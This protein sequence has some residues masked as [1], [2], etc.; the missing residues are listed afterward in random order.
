MCCDQEQ[1]LLPPNRERL[2]KSNEDPAQSKI[3]KETVLKKKTDKEPWSTE[4]PDLNKKRKTHNS[5][6]EH[7]PAQWK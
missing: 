6:E 7:H 5:K 1:S 4:V 3:K 2:R